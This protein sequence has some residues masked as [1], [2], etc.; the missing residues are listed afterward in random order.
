MDN[1][2]VRELQDHLLNAGKLITL[3]EDKINAYL[4][5]ILK[6]MSS[7]EEL[8]PSEYYFIILAFYNRLWELSKQHGIQT[9]LSNADFVNKVHRRFVSNYR[10]AGGIVYR[11]QMSYDEYDLFGYI[12]EKEANE[13]LV[14]QLKEMKEVYQEC[15]NLLK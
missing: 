13:E 10:E 15:C 6:K 2:I 3:N 11:A 14:G 5:E 9:E 1:N 7:Y 8:E 12:K 4:N